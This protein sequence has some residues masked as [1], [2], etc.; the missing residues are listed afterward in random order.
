MMSLTAPAGAPISTTGP[1]SGVSGNSGGPTGA[2]PS[3]YVADPSIFPGLLRASVTAARP[4][5]P[6]ETGRAV[7]TGAELAGM[8]VPFGILTAPLISVAAPPGPGLTAD[9][10]ASGSAFAARSMPMHSGPRGALDPRAELIHG[11][12]PHL[13]ATNQPPTADATASPAAVPALVS[14]NAGDVAPAGSATSAVPEAAAPVPPT[15]TAAQQPLPDE[16]FTRLDGHNPSIAARYLE[17]IRVKVTAHQSSAGAQ[18]TSSPEAAP[19]DAA[20]LGATTADTVTATTA[21]PPPTVDAT[22]RL[23]DEARHGERGVDETLESP[24]GGLGP[25]LTGATVTA[26]IASR[27]DA[28]VRTADAGAV[29][30]DAATATV[31]TAAGAGTIGGLIGGAVDQ[32]AEA[33]TLSIREGLTEATISLRPAALGAVKV[34]ITAGADGLVIRMTAERDAVGDLLRG[35]MGELREAL[36]AR[37]VAVAELHVLHNPPAVTSPDTAPWQ[38]RSAPRRDGEQTPH[39]AREG[40]TQDEEAAG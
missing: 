20:A 27:T 21:M 28:S 6:A 2:T 10:G 37:Q 18:P 26:G 16:L 9:G 31:S 34:Q 38:E 19:A 36:A 4:E 7:Q 15:A 11:P 5:P 25:A 23:L 32:V 35:H 39:D 1:V 30:T 13:P 24:A 3:G 14:G 8:V 29:S 12:G 33:L 17:G 22:R 40:D